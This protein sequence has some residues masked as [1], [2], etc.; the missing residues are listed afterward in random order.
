MKGRIPVKFPQVSG[1]DL[2]GSEIQIPDQLREQYNILIVAFQRWHQQLVN[3]WVPFLERIVDD[4]PNTEYYELP[5]IREMNRLY[6]YFINSGMRAGI[7][8]EDTRGRTITLYIDKEAFNRAVG[9]SNEENIHVYL[10]K[11]D[12]QILWAEEGAFAEDK[13]KSLE[14]TLMSVVHSKDAD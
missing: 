1:E 5:T 6:R 14:T 13:G 7:P 9:I 11:R 3:S 10:V 12:G 4:Y 8:S 2:L